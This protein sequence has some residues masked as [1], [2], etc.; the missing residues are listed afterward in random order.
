MRR[1]RRP[2]DRGLRGAHVAS[3][4]DAPPLYRTS[5]RSLASSPPPRARAAPATP[6]RGSSSR[7]RH[8]VKVQLQ[9]ILRAAY[10]GIDAQRAQS[11]E[12]LVDGPA[13]RSPGTRRSRTSR[14]S[15][16]SC[17]CSGTP[18][19]ASACQGE[20]EENPDGTLRDTR[21]IPGGRG[22]SLFPAC[23]NMM[24][25]AHALGVSSLFTTFF[26]LCA[27]RGQAAPARAA[28]HVHR[29]R[30]VPRVRRRAAAAAPRC[31]SHSTEVVHLDDLGGAVPAMTTIPRIVSADD[32]VVEPPDVFTS[33]LPAKYRDI[34]PHVVRAPVA[35][36]TFRGGNFAYAD[37]HHGRRRTARRLLALRGPAVA[38]HPA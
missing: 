30:G 32:H 33:R 24:L 34:G 26:G 37:G 9:A 15:A 31:A 14:S 38:A 2:T 1:V 17:S 5:L 21:E 27:A 20:Y 8:G 4:P 19:A 11:P 35:E 16:P 12:Q 25:A 13:V 7:H 3:T 29:R 10:A 22:S 36:M 23:Q 6:S 28:A 18:T